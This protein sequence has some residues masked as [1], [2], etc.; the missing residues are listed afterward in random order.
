MNDN[1]I[2]RFRLDGQTVVATDLLRHG[3]DLGGTPCRHHDVRAGLCHAERDALADAAAAPRN[4]HGL[5]VEP[6][7][8]Q[9]A[10]AAPVTFTRD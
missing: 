8:V 6:E 9:N 2:D 10:H 1:I 5:S 3:L 7:S 4:D